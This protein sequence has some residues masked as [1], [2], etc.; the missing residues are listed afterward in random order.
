[1]P[2]SGWA[3]EPRPLSLC[4]RSLCSST[5]GAA[6]VRGPRTAK[7]KKKRNMAVELE[8]DR[9]GQRGGLVITVECL[10]SV[11]RAVD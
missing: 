4:V 1:M 2:W 7:K 9:G 5:G 10:D 6:T 8:E 3:H 11:L